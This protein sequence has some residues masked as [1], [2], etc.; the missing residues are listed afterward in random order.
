MGVVGDDIAFFAHHAEQ[1][2]LG[3]SA[4]VGGDDVLVA[5]DILDRRAELLEAAAAGVAFVPFHDGRPLVSG[6]GSG[7]GI[8]EQVDEDIVGGEEEEVVVRGAEQLLAL[9]AGGAANGFDAFD[10]EG[11]DDGAGHD[12]SFLTHRG[13]PPIHESSSASCVCAGSFSSSR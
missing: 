11:F 7:A 1:N 3:G 10:A 2:A 8:G 4:L 5:E 9:R 13:S 12:F 6:H